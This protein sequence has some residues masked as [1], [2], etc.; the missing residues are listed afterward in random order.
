MSGV[1]SSQKRGKSELE[2]TLKLR[3]STYFYSGSKQA[4]CHQYFQNYPVAKIKESVCVKLA[5]IN[6]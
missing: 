1:V 3:S 6:T 4:C 5:Y 2:K